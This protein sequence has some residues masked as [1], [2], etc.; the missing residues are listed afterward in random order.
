[1]NKKIKI[2]V[3]LMVLTLTL[4]GCKKDYKGYWCNYTETSTIVIQ[5][6]NEI[7]E[8]EKKAVEDKISSFENIESSHFYSKEDYGEELAND[9]ELHAA[10]VVFFSSM[11]HIGTYIEELT[12]MAGVYSAEQSSAKTNISLYNLKSW[13]KY[14]FTDSDEALE[15]D[16]EKG[17]YKIKKGVITFT[18]SGENKST[19]LLYTKDG[20][21]CG[22]SDCTKIYARSNESCTSEN[23]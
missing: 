8:K 13:N 9:E 15:Q 14:T 2:L 22:D 12:E 17:K 6:K 19:K 11:D 5:L 21:L 23:K 16:V 3:L 20:L 1:M 18:P 4:T 10:Y 7:S